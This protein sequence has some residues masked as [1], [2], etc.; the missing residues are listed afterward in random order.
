[1]PQ[2]PS[3]SVLFPWS[4]RDAKMRLAARSKTTPRKV[5]GYL[6]LKV[7]SGCVIHSAMFKREE[8][9]VVLPSEY[10]VPRY[11]PQAKVQ[12]KLTK[13]LSRHVLTQT[14]CSVSRWNSSAEEWQLLFKRQMYKT[15]SE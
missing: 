1:M 11:A 13:T 5:S 8:L 12:N 4:T 6:S 10:L 15:V 2:L 14:D 7:L 9:V 3:I